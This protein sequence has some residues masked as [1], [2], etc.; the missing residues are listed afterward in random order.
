MYHLII[1][2][3][4]GHVYKAQTVLHLYLYWIW[5]GENSAI[6]IKT[7]YQCIRLSDYFI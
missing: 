2:I 6:G 5:I 4:Q 1:H 7:P 3:F